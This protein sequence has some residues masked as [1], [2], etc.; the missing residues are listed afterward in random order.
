MKKFIAAAALSALAVP[1]VASAAPSS[2]DRAEGQ[3]ECRTMLRTVDT[4]ANFL[5]IVKLEANA[6]SR[7]AFGRCV[8]VRSADAQDERRESR[9]SAVAECRVLFPRPESS[10]GRPA[11]NEDR[12]AFGKCVSEKAKAKND[13]ADRE[14]RRETLNPAKA[15]RKEQTDNPTKFGE[16]YGTKRNAFGKC[17]S[18]KAQA[19]ND[20]E[21]QEQ[22]PV[23][24]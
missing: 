6:N 20:D 5:Q 17:V 23:V 8:V 18:K 1:G 11:E 4:R 24:L 12:N 22:A 7:N 2:A 13:E 16:D 3:R 10:P 21:Q 19:Q 14:Q 15:C 9:N